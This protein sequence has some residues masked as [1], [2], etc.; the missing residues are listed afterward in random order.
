MPQTISSAAAGRLTRIVVAL[1]FA[2]LFPL[3]VYAQAG[4]D[5]KNKQAGKGAATP[6][7]TKD[8]GKKAADAPD[9]KAAKDADK[10]DD[11]AKDDDDDDDDDEIDANTV[12]K[13]SKVELIIDPAAEAATENTFPEVRGNDRINNYSLLE[14]MARGQGQLNRDEVRQYVDAQAVI[15]SKHSN[16][17]ALLTPNAVKQTS[18]TAGGA[19]RDTRQAIARSTREMLTLLALSEGNGPFRNLLIENLRRVL[20]PLLNGHLFTRTQAI[21]VLE[22]TGSPELIDVFAKV[23]A[24]SK[25]PLA[26]KMIA[27]RG[28]TK[29]ANHGRTLGLNPQQSIKASAAIANSLGNESD[30]FWFGQ[31]RGLE[32][33][34]SLRYASDP[35]HLLANR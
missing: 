35:T 16:I 20:E 2:A 27:A 34:G 30:G 9:G 28:L 22:Q 33:L 10:A 12:A 24:N 18:N 3:L 21:I 17:Q 14:D 31:V 11:K 5:P 1:V 25:Q 23:L 29:I 8:D 15:L 26:V 13:I 6:P 7:A 4:D 32:A 19:G